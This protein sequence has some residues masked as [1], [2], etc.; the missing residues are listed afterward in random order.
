MAM[1]KNPLKD[2]KALSGSAEYV[3]DVGGFKRAVAS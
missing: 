2:A 1:I 3:S